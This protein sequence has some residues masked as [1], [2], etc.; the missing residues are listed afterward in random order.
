MVDLDKPVK[1]IALRNS[2]VGRGS[3]AIEGGIYRLVCTNGMLRSDQSTMHRWS[4]LGSAHRMRGRMLGA[5]NAVLAVA[6]GTVQHYYSALEVEIDDLVGWMESELG[7]S[8]R[9]Q[10]RIVTA[11]NHRTTT[12]GNTLASVV[13]AITLDAQ[14]Y[15]R[16]ERRREQEKLARQALYRGLSTARDGRIRAV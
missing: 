8:G 3:V 10:S 4:H 14:R 7:V 6:A 16:P 11:L 5:L 1:M 15:H 2:E 13:D 12:P 9:Q